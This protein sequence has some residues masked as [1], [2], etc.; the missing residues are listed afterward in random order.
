MM[1]WSYIHLTLF[2]DGEKGY[3]K[4]SPHLG[5]L[6][7]RP[8]DNEKNNGFEQ[9]NTVMSS[10]AKSR[11]VEEDALYRNNDVK[12]LKDEKSTLTKS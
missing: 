10:S 5:K 6:I 4:S 9:Y 8:Y 12:E 3:G 2:D 7:K 1:N 11:N